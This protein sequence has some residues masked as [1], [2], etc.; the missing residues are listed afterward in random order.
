MSEFLSSK[1]LPGW[2]GKVG[3]L[4]GF[5]G[6]G[7]YAIGINVAINGLVGRSLRISIEWGPI[8]SS[9]GA[10]LFCVAI[11]VLW[12]LSLIRLMLLVAL[13]GLMIW[14]VVAAKEA[15]GDERRTG[16]GNIRYFPRR[17]RATSGPT[18]LI[19]PDQSQPAQPTKP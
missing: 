7:L 16:A 4:L 12:R 18:G 14:V 3:F 2:H 9:V 1:G 5:A 6:M 17:A 13:A 10:A 19:G 11:A 15:H 8:I